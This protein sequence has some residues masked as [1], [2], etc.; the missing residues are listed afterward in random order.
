MKDSWQWGVIHA[1]CPKCGEVNLY[2]TV[3]ENL[4]IKC[5]A[6]HCKY[7]RWGHVVVLNP[8]ECL[9]CQPGD[10]MSCITKDGRTQV[11]EI[12]IL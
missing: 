10:G 12:S 5:Y 2:E 6:T 11:I 3:A 8:V 9:A 4:S 1:C 7:C